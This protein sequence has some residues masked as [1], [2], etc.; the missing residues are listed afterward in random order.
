[1]KEQIL[2]PSG[3]LDRPGGEDRTVTLWHWQMPKPLG[4]GGGDKTASGIRS[5]HQNYRG[6]CTF[7]YTDE[8]QMEEHSL[9]N[10]LQQQRKDTL[11]PL[12]LLAQTQFLRMGLR[13]EICSRHMCEAFLHL[14]ILDF[15]L[16]YNQGPQN[17]H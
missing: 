3:Q 9:E 16:K 4:Q 8:R 13:K 6:C 10:I 7:Q 14:L 15:P 17:Q 5:G 2:R 11:P 1:M 12:P